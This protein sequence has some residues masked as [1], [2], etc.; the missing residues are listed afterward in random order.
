VLIAGE[1]GNQDWDGSTYEGS[2]IIKKDGYYYYFGSVGTCCEG[3][4]STYRVVV[5]R[6]ES[7]TGPYTD[8][9]GRK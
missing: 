8:K 3:K 5:G 9:A 6:S 1:P 2:Y 7:I 4:N